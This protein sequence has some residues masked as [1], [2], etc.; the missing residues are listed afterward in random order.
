MKFMHNLLELYSPENIIESLTSYLT[1]ERVNKIEEI[2]ARRLSS[3]Q[4]AI[5]SPYDIHNAFAVV[6]SAE[7][8]GVFN[9]HFVNA[10]LKKGQGRST[11]R[12]TLKWVNLNNHRTISA[13]KNK[14]TNQL[15]VG[16]SA[17]GEYLLQELPLDK[18]ICFLFGNESQGLTVEAKKKC[19]L[20]FR[21]PMHGMV[22]SLNLS[23]SAAISL[24]DYLNRKRSIMKKPGDLSSDEYLKEKANF[25][26]RSVGI[27]MSRVIL[28]KK[29]SK[30]CL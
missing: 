6:R 12:G 24:Y 14:Q 11:T 13:F 28:L 26:I 5:E 22:E 8:L 2:L 16:A 1:R 15:L 3:V 29:S 7:A 19:D 20:L 23:V 4:I 30:S 17:C 21:I 18:P 10:T 27:D 25:Y 9:I